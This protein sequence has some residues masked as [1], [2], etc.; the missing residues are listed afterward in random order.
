MNK[1]MIYIAS[2]EKKNDVANICI[3]AEIVG[4]LAIH[5]DI[6]IRDGELCFSD[7]WV[8]THVE[9]GLSLTRQKCRKHAK[10]YAETYITKFNELGGKVEFIEKSGTW[11][12][13]KEAF[14]AHQYARTY[15]T[16]RKG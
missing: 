5:P 7:Y 12:V 9:S 14:N 8:V 11:S 1:G 15:M 16:V 6:V 4:F 10:R 3:E 13:N 2:D